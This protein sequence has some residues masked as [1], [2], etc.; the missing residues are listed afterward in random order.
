MFAKKARTPLAGPE[1]LNTDV[2][3]DKSETGKVLREVEPVL[4]E[5][6]ATVMH[7]VASLEAA[8]QH[9]VASSSDQTPVLGVRLMKGVPTK[10]EQQLV[11]DPVV[12][13]PIVIE[14]AHKTA[15][16]MAAEVPADATIH[17]LD[18][19]RSRRLMKE[20]AHRQISEAF[21]P[22]RVIE[23]TV[24]KGNFAPTIPD[25]KIV[26]ETEQVITARAGVEAALQSQA[27][28]ARKIEQAEKDAESLKRFL[29]QHH[30]QRRAAA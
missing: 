4:L 12:E 6:K 15:V 22:E 16:P 3:N 13:A 10:V 27:E 11:T 25:L 18:E 1:S 19:A 7:A 5:R 29:A 21:E 20:D 9:Q 28:A 8:R 30:E 26:D 23:A 14:P 2:I 17:Q 24:I